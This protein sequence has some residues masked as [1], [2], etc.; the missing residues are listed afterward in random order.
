MHKVETVREGAGLRPSAAR[1][2]EQRFP[3]ALVASKLARVLRR[4]SITHPCV[5]EAYALNRLDGNWLLRCTKASGP[6]GEVGACLTPGTQLMGSMTPSSSRPVNQA[7]RQVL[8]GEQPPAARS[9]A[10]LV[11]RFRGSNHIDASINLVL[12]SAHAQTSLR[13]LRKL[14]CGARVSKDGHKRDR[15]SGH[16]SR[17]RTASRL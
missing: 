13:S 15:A 14:D 3:F 8:P 9:L 10:L 2:R 6:C 5:G 4:L 1:G 17:R 16:P 12:R 11:L 7:C